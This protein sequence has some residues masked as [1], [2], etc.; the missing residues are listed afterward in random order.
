MQPKLRLL[1]HNVRPE[2]RSGW[3]YA[4]ESLA[5]LTCAGGVLTDTFLEAS[6]AWHV[7]PMLSR[8]EL[9]YRQPWLGFLHNPVGI[10]EWHEYRSA[11][12]VIFTQPA[13]RESLPSC[14]G[15]LTLSEDFAA[16]VRGQLNVPVLALIH[17]TEEPLK[18]FSWE[19]FETNPKKRV[20]QVGWWLRRM[21]SIYQLPL[22]RLRPANREA[23]FAGMA[24]GNREAEFAGM[25]PGNREAEFAGM[26]PGNREAEFAWMAPAVLEPLGADKI[27]QF[28]R[29]LEREMAC[30]N[31]PPLPT[32]ERI[33][34]CDALEFDELLARNLVF[35]DIID[36]TANNTV[37]ECIVRHTP[38]LVNRLT[39]VVEYL[40]ADY[41]FYFDSLTEAARKVEDG[42]CVKAAH[43][44]L[45]E[46]P[47]QRF[48]GEY[49]RSSLAESSLYRA[50]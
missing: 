40:G 16:W 29:V 5:P 22:R 20:I 21:A 13:W 24:P 23:E 7:G 49:F 4:I 41:P 11:P 10:P 27:A 31:L 28:D 18:K 8:G 2:H 19:A 43:Q 42:A 17:P 9:P 33:P 35:A 38:I 15:I 48:T 45:V 39:A 44:Y 25:A 34:Y 36:A 1:D 6:F 12:Q 3:K 50:L 26:A 37:V 30:R 32:I 14:R 46:M 47:K